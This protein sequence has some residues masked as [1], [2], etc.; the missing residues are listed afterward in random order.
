MNF[1]F[2]D[3]LKH[4]LATPQTQ[5]QPRPP[6]PIIEPLTA[7]S[8]NVGTHTCTGMAA[9]FYPRVNPVYFPDGVVVQKKRLPRFG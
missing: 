3:Y 5:P 8:T 2:S 7:Q 1:K 4:K 9:S 6:Q